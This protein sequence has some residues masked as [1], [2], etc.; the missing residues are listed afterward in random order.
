M[1]ARKDKP[2][3][4][5]ISN[6]ECRAGLRL[7][8]EILDRIVERGKMPEQVVARAQEFSGYLSDLDNP[9]KKLKAKDAALLRSAI[10]ANT[11]PTLRI[12]PWAVN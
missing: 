10:L 9:R 5:V 4:P 3:E 2:S 8:E 7:V 11:L 12:F 1:K 6:S